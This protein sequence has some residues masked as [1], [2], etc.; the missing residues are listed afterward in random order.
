MGNNSFKDL[1]DFGTFFSGKIIQESDPSLGWVWA[2]V[3][4]RPGQNKKVWM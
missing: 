3:C 1:I 4:L 2:T